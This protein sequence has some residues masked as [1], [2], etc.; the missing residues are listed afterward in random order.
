M[1]LRLYEM[2]FAAAKC[3]LNKQLSSCPTSLELAKETLSIL[4]KSNE[5]WIRNYFNFLGKSLEQKITQN[6]GKESIENVWYHWK[7]TIF[8]GS[9]LN[10]IEKYVPFKL[11]LN[12]ISLWRHKVQIMQTFHFEV[13]WNLLLNTDP[14]LLE[15]NPS[16]NLSP[17]LVPEIFRPFS[18]LLKFSYP[19]DPLELNS[20]KH[21]L[22]F[23]LVGDYIE[24]YLI[25]FYLTQN[26]LIFCQNL[27]RF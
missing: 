9:F 21:L 15:I 19:S 5:V 16:K 7:C 20:C 17:Y 2:S 25:T 22:V 10:G 8:L 6:T 1:P 13:F 11:S 23:A 3:H 4:W 18:V 12:I 27:P 14:R 24:G 26:V